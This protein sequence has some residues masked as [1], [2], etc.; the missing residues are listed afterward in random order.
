MLER[1]LKKVHIKNFARG[2]N[3]NILSSQEKPY[4]FLIE[5]FTR[6]LMKKTLHISLKLLKSEKY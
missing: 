3:L 1:K 2:S 6:L 5:G 4:Q